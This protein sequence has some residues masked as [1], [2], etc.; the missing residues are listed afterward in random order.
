MNPCVTCCDTVHARP[1]TH[2]FPSALP[3]SIPPHPHEIRTGG[4][5]NG[6]DGLAVD[7]QGRLV[8]AWKAEVTTTTRVKEFGAHYHKAVRLTAGSRH[9]SRGRPGQVLTM[10]TAT[11]ALR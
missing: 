4:W 1:V 3:A 9:P 2:L 11:T 8:S 10:P 7:D 6:D 5:D